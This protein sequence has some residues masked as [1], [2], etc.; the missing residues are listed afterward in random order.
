M[1]IYLAFVQMGIEYTRYADDMSFSPLNPNDYSGYRQLICGE[2]T[3]KP[4]LSREVLDI[5]QGHGFR[6]NGKKINCSMVN[7]VSR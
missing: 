5:I 7:P 1:K 3:G 2:N 4:A 6:I